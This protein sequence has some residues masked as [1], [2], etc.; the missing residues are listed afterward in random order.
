[1]SS[2]QGTFYCPGEVGSKL[3][4]SNP[5]RDAHAQLL[6]NQDRGEPGVCQ[7]YNPYMTEATYALC[8]V[9]SLSDHHPISIEL[10]GLKRTVDLLKRRNQFLEAEIVKADLAEADSRSSSQPSASEEAQ[11][12]PSFS[13]PYQCVQWL[14]NQ[15]DV[16]CP[17]ASSLGGA[18]N[19]LHNVTRWRI[20]VT[21][22]RITNQGSQDQVVN[23]MP[24]VPRGAP[25]AGYDFGCVQ[26]NV[27][28]EPIQCTAISE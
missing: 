3:S 16:T 6:P 17:A 23:L 26:R 19:V 4:S 20:D 11:S 22:R 13:N 5:L 25:G 21:V 9:V 7:V 1:M 18:R 2:E 14:S 27:R 10:D 8:L 15:F 28:L 24:N 12:L